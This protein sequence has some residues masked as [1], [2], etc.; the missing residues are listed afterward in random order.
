MPGQRPPGMEL[1]RTLLIKSKSEGAKATT[2]TRGQRP[3]LVLQPG[4]GATTGTRLRRGLGLATGRRAGATGVRALTF[5]KRSVAKIM[6]TEEAE[7]IV[8]FMYW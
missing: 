6:N 2:H 3:P 4:S 5:S 1:Y 8:P 7:G